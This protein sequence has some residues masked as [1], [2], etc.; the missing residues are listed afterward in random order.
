MALDRDTAGRIRRARFAF[1]GMAPTP[2]RLIEAEHA[3]E[4]SAW[5]EAAVERVQ[6]VI[7]RSLSPMTDHRGSAQ[8][9]LEVAKRLVEKF[10]WERTP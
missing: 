8:F 7:A 9:R 10:D 4:G 1:G 6:G 2:V 5:N 3:I